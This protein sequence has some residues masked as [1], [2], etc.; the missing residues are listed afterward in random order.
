MWT[1][2]FLRTRYG[3]WS[4]WKH[5][6]ILYTGSE[7]KRKIG[8]WQIRLKTFIFPSWSSRFLASS[9]YL[10]LPRNLHNYALML[11]FVLSVFTATNFKYFAFLRRMKVSLKRSSCRFENVAKVQILAA[12][13]FNLWDS[14][15]LETSITICSDEEFI[16]LL[17]QHFKFLSRQNISTKQNPQIPAFQKPSPTLLSKHIKKNLHHIFSPRKICKKSPSSQISSLLYSPIV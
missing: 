15:I 9:R 12:S 10:C 16:V 8:F 17:L 7:D 13:M 1:S 5:R 6:A 11:G 4:V 14:C 3:H 2:L